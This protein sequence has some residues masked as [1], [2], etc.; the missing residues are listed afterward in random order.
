[1]D[2]T[3]ATQFDESCTKLIEAVHTLIGAGSGPERYVYMMETLTHHLLGSDEELEEKQLQ[4]VKDTSG[5]PLGGHVTADLDLDTLSPVDTQQLVAREVE[6]VRG[7]LMGT[8]R[9]LQEQ[10]DTLSARLAALENKS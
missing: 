7:E 2:F 6:K 4:E 3:D 1:M 8:V 10:V 9:A 5:A